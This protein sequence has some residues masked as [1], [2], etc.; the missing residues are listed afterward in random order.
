MKKQFRYFMSGMFF[1]T[2]GEEY[3]INIPSPNLYDSREKAMEDQCFGYRFV[4]LDDAIGPQIAVFE[5]EKAKIAVEDN[6][7][8]LRSW[9]EGNVLKM[10]SFEE[11]KEAN[12]SIRMLKPE[13]KG[14]CFINGNTDFVDTDKT[15]KDVF[16]DM[17]K[18]KL[19]Y[20]DSEAY[21]IE[22]VNGK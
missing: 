22:E 5:K 15:F 2:D 11:F 13:C 4:W 20:I 16:P 21:W 3:E 10:Y 1:P 8:F 12:G 6:E 18:Q 9:V 19:Y 17:Q 14:R 7:R